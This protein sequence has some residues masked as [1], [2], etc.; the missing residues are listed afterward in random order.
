MK[1][2][3]VKENIKFR[4]IANPPNTRWSGYHDNLVSVLHLKKALQNLAASNE[5]WAEHS[6]TASEWKLIDGAVQLLKPVRDTIKAWEGEMEPT[7]HRVV[8]RIY[9]MHCI[10]DGFIDNPVNNMCG[11][12]FARELK[13]QIDSRFP[14]KGTDN[15]LRRIANYLAP[16]FKGIYLEE[17][18]ALE[19]TKEEIELE[20]A[21][22]APELI[23]T[24]A[25]VAPDADEPEV[26]A[27]VS[28]TTKLRNRIQA[29]QQRMY[30]PNQNE[31]LS[32]VRREMLRYESFSLS[33]KAVNI[34]YWWRDHEKVLPCLAR[35]A[36]H[37]LTIPASS[38]KSERVFS[39]G[40]N[41]VTAKR[42]RVALKK[43][44]DLIKENK[45]KIEAFKIRGVYDLVNVGSEPFVKISVDE[46]LANLVIEDEN[47]TDNVE[48][49]HEDYEEEVLF[50]EDYDSDDDYES[51]EDANTDEIIDL[52]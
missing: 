45:A 35:L 40:G 49:D 44:E 5:N 43:V 31:R 6:F 25:Q 4:K 16:Q 23:Q 3:C 11:I 12:G 46:V 7:M 39:T 30:T 26:T 24:E 38:A 36:K 51:E 29:R 52:M 27:P 20:V 18:D 22:I 19:T 1:R 37:V 17:M 48:Q 41:F 2:E 13:K 34:L 15:K 8:E 10:I 14:K 33:S 9:T 28:P 21:R 47:D 42:N 32:T 50:V